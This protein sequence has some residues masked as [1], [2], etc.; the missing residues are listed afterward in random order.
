MKSNHGLVVQSRRVRLL[1]QYVQRKARRRPNPRW[2]RPNPDSTRFDVDS[3]LF[4]FLFYFYS[5]ESSKK[6]S[7]PIRRGFG[8]RKSSRIRV[9]STQKRRIWI[10]PN[11]NFLLEGTAESMLSN[12]FGFGR[13]RIR[14]GSTSIRPN[15]NRRI[16][17]YS[18]ESRFGRI[19]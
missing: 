17:V 16:F 9:Y 19:I 5:A 4:W 18:T 1:I 8:R 14:R 6:R 15:F 7:F 10:R 13:I 11:P 2:I 12:I 3:T